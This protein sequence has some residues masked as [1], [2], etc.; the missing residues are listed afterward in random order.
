[1]KLHECYFSRRVV[2]FVFLL[3]IVNS[4][5]L[6]AETPDP[7][8]SLAKNRIKRLLFFLEKCILLTSF[9]FGS[10]VHW[11]SLARYR[12]CCISFRAGPFNTRDSEVMQMMWCCDEASAHCQKTSPSS[13]F[14][15]QEKFIL[16]TETEGVKWTTRRTHPEK[17]LLVI[18]IWIIIRKLPS[19]LNVKSISH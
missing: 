18:S 16:Q 5:L 1:M 12:K 11:I 13:T 14:L 15:L 10:C 3:K 4:M 9:W 19:R 17:K 6:R 7:P 8:P 2:F